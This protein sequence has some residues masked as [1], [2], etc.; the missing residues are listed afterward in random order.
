MARI[1]IGIPCFN[2]EAFIAGSIISALRQAEQTP[3]IEIIVSDNKS[4]DQTVEK[5]EAVLEAMPK[6]APKVRLFKQ[7]DNMGVER[8]FWHVFDHS[9]SELFL[10]LGAHDQISAG[11]VSNGLDH[12]QANSTTSMFCGGHKTLALSGAVIEQPIIYDFN[13][14]NPIERYLKSIVEINNCYIFHSIF[15]RHVFNG[16]KRKP[17]PSPD[18]ILIS[19]SLWAGK[20]WQSPDCH[21]MRRYFPIENRLANSRLDHRY[22]HA[23]NNINFYDAYLS[24]LE[25]LASRLPAPI[26][27]S[28]LQRASD[29]LINRF[30]LPF[31]TDSVNGD[32]AI[33][34]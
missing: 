6:N 26:K 9:D 28:I 4:T 8:N 31:I 12:L 27:S 17:T 19:R 5:I 29:L 3:D 32:S 18:H 16:Y 14:E 15:R 11:Y 34:K 22:V 1:A 33:K 21:Y 23:S 20:L 25:S 7:Q 2:E 10:W 24:D 30:G 13:Q